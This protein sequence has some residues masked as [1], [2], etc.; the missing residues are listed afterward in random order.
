MQDIKPKLFIGS[1]TEG[2]PVARAVQS[3]LETDAEATI[4]NQGFF[5][6]SRATLE[7]LVQDA[8]TFDFSLIIAHGDDRL[9]SRGS[10]GTLAPRDNVI[11]ELGLF[12]G[13]LGR[14]RTFFLFNRTRPPKLP[15]DIAGVTALTY[16]NRDDGNLRAA[17]GPACQQIRAQI[18]K[19]GFK[20]NP[21]RTAVDLANEAYRLMQSN[22]NRAIELSKLALKAEPSYDLPQLVIYGSL[23]ALGRYEEAL[24]AISELLRIHPNHPEAHFRRGHLFWSLGRFKEALD[25]LNRVIS[26]NA[27]HG[28]ALHYRGRVLE[29]L[30][31]ASDAL[32]S[33]Q[34]AVDAGASTKFG[35]KSA[36]RI[37]LLTKSDEK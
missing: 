28:A 7:T 27:A 1:S 22:P 19:L 34:K 24:A 23:R 35:R 16:A 31:S 13:V 2:L 15:T 4:W 30:G 26:L 36:L 25:D 9:D 5:A 6:P 33:Y 37:T 17:L 29:S 11:F 8:P 32:S 14:K 3:E 21:H 10:E 18:E 12:F 20:N